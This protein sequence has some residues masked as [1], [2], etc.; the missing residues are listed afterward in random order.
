MWRECALRSAGFPADG[1]EALGDQELAEVARRSF[2]E[3]GYRA[4]FEEQWPAALARS[5]AVARSLARDPRFREAVAWQNPAMVRNCLD[6]TRLR[7]KHELAI[8]S[9][10]QR[11]MVKNDTI[12]FFGP[13]AWASWTDTEPPVTVAPGPE[14]VAQRRLYFETWAIDALARRLGQVPELQP[15]LRP[16]LVASCLLDGSVLRRPYGAPVELTVEQAA[17]LS[18]CDGN[19][20]SRQLAAES[21]VAV[22]ALLGQLHTW[23][24]AGIVHFDLAGPVEAR[25]EVSL[26]RELEQ[27]GEAGPRERALATL[28][29]V[30]SARDAVA[31]AAGDAD[32]VL[33]KVT[34]LERVFERVTGSPPTRRPGEAYAGRTLVYEDSLR[35]VTVA[36]GRPLVELLAPPL[37]LV[38]DSCRWL[39][40]RAAERY[41][42]VLH[43]LFDQCAGRSGSEPVPAA[44]LLAA[45]TPHFMGHNPRP[46]ADALAEFQQRWARILSVPPGARHHNV[47]VESIAPAVRTAFPPI[48]PRW[49]AAVHHSPDLLIGA[50]GAGPWPVEDLTLVLGELHLARNTME[51]RPLVEFHERPARLFTAVEADH[52]T[53]RVYHVPPKEWP[54]VN[55]RTYPSPLLSPLFNY[56]CLYDDSSGAPGPVLPAAGLTVHRRGGRLVV[57]SRTDGAELDLLEM[58]GEQLSNAVATAFRIMP[59]SSAHRPR[60]TIGRLV[61]QRESWTFDSG[62]IPW[63]AQSDRAERYRLAQQWRE[64]NQLPARAFYKVANEKPVFVDFR[65]VSLLEMMARTIR[66]VSADPYWQQISLSE[67]LPDTDQAWLTD[68]QGRGY[69]AEIRCVAVDR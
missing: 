4:K 41:E 7:R 48:S 59:A 3:P 16:R 55:S 42:Q 58:L 14:V 56:W 29:E 43:D 46:L 33:A 11:Y 61:V 22:E 2:G 39:V 10:A 13:L 17:I 37:A 20:T 25:P 44:S 30:E 65:S 34:T 8:A 5:H 21:G 15:W 50:S 6:V 53:R 1:I 9:Y 18:R 32:A 63:A 47:T 35:N 38:L 69:T 66:R 68:A 26:R 57:R 28:A 67:M 24:E 62:Q 51:N 27:V 12:G 49:A 31:A 54:Q 60:V 40:G 45:T 64:T 52:G 19:R 23:C 36:L